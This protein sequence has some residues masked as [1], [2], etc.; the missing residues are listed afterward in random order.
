MLLWLLF[1]V[2]Q[3][4]RKQ[5]FYEKKW[6]QNEWPGLYCAF[7]FNRSCKYKQYGSKFK[8]PRFL[9]H[10][11]NGK[12]GAF[13][14]VTCGDVFTSRAMKLVEQM[15]SQKVLLAVNLG[16][17]SPGSST[18][19]YSP[20]LSNLRTSDILTPPCQHP[21]YSPTPPSLKAIY[22]SDKSQGSPGEVGNEDLASNERR[23][24]RMPLL[25]NWCQDGYSAEQA[26]AP[27]FTK[28]VQWG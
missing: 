5:L 13:Q 23:G 28:A 1:D 7:N 12:Y 20:K 27:W 19:H 17:N 15:E 26:A 18:P 24:R 21:S 10:A 16:S 14:S 8:A 25:L 11:E 2:L 22:L 9:C 4:E 6:H 3:L